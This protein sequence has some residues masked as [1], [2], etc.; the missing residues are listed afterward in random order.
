MSYLPSLIKQLFYK[1][2]IIV[3]PTCFL[4]IMLQDQRGLPEEVHNQGISTKLHHLWNTKTET[5]SHNTT[6]R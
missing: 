1:T 5:L 6:V 2:L 4:V 3:H